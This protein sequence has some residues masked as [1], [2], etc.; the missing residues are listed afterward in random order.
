MAEEELYR[1]PYTQME[2]HGSKGLL[3]P[4]MVTY[5][6]DSPQINI[7]DMCSSDSIVPCKQIQENNYLI[8]NISVFGTLAASIEY[9]ESIDKQ[10]VMIY[11][12]SGSWDVSGLKREAP[13]EQQLN[14][15]DQLNPRKKDP[16][17]RQKDDKQ[18]KQPL[19]GAR[20]MSWTVYNFEKEFEQGF[21]DSSDSE[22]EHYGGR[23]GYKKD[24]A[25]DKHP[26]LED[27]DEIRDIQWNRSRPILA[28][29]AES[30][31]GQSSAIW[32]VHE[33]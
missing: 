11:D 9:N 7:W 27:G 6:K 8:D 25:A 14:F 24:G 26:G 12:I 17:Q 33:D 1:M 31:H 22:Q 3:L 23:G 18:Q 29:A 16:K 13:E 21:G 28:F 32:V 15:T 20:M 4:A 5:S 2:A 30:K 10:F 19:N